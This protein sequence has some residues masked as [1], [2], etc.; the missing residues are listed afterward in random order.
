M[1]Y[2]KKL[3]ISLEL[4][5]KKSQVEKNKKERNNKW[6]LNKIKWLLN[7]IEMMTNMKKLLKESYKR[8]EKYIKLLVGTWALIACILIVLLKMT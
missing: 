4:K 8:E 5:D 7:K 6:L 1:P 2:L 3:E